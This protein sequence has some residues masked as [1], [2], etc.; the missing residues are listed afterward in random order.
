MEIDVAI[1]T[2]GIPHRWPVAVEAETK[3][4][5]CEV[6]AADKKY[7][8]DLRHLPLL[9]LSM[10]KMPVI[11]TTLS[12]VNPND[13]GVGVCMSPLPMSLTMSQSTVRLIAR[14]SDRGTSVYFPDFVV[15]MLPEILSNGL[16]SLNPKIDRLA[17]VCEMTVS[18]PGQDQ[19][20]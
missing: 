10:V 1:R 8:V 6:T 2:H 19:W 9:S 15:P 4:L 16:C 18:A 7:R 20:L 11:L 17:M 3:L 5:A 13:Q 12:I 14:P